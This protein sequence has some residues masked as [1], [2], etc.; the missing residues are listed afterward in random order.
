[1]WLVGPANSGKTMIFK[2]L[3]ESLVRYATIKCSSAN[4]FAFAGAEGVKCLFLDE[5]AYD[6]K[7]EG[8]LK[9]LFAGQPF[10]APKKH[11]DDRTIA[12][13]PVL[14]CTNDLPFDM[15][16]NVWKARITQYTVK[17]CVELFREDT[18]ILKLHPMAWPKVF[19]NN[20]DY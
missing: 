8:N 16:N 18:R 17:D 1:M 5:F 3:A 15:A 2:S 13:V 7:N 10:P 9:E 11:Q 4:I 19:K 6:E 20:G 12:P 14:M